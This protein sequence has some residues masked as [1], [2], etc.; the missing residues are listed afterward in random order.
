MH[1]IRPWMKGAGSKNGVKSD[2]FVPPFA[3]L[4]KLRFSLRR[5]GF[6]L[7]FERERDDGLTL[8]WHGF[9]KSPK[10]FEKGKRKSP[11]EQGGGKKAGNGKKRPTVLPRGVAVI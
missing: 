11:D 1:K 4:G 6:C 3:W 9:Q 2:T 8:L 7:V 10:K 5:K